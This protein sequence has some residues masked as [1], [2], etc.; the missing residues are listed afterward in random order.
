VLS[1]PYG[2]EPVVYGDLVI[3][4]EVVAYEASSQNKALDAHFAHLIVHGILHLQG[5]DH[6]EGE[7][8]ALRME[9]REREILATLGFADPYAGED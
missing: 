9:D 1:F 5:Y 3:C 6:E 2:L 8:E 7:Q 4:A